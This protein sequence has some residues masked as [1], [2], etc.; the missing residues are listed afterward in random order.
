MASGN[1]LADDDI[2]TVKV[3]VSQLN[4]LRKLVRLNRTGGDKADPKTPRDKADPKTDPPNSDSDFSDLAD[5]NND[6]DVA[7]LADGSSGAS[8]SDGDPDDAAS[9]DG[10]VN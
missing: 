3:Q 5:G 10:D 7:D 2:V 8:D 4:R 9:G 1:Q 6:S